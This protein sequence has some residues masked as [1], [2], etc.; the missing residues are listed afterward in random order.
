[1][2]LA[3]KKIE[4]SHSGENMAAIIHKVARTYGFRDKLGY[5]VMD[6]A[7]N[8]DTMMKVI[9]KNLYDVDGVYYDPVEH[10]L[11]CIG[12]IINLFVQAFLFGD[13]PD[14]DD[15]V[16]TAGPT[17]AELQAYRKFEPLGKLHNVI[18]Y[19]MHSTQRIQRFKA[20]SKGVMPVRD[21]KIRWNTWFMVLERALDKIKDA[22]QSF[23]F[24]EKELANDVL[25]ASDWETLLN[26][27]NFLQPFYEATK[28]C[29]GRKA[30][31]NRV[32]PVL[33]FLLEK[34]E[35]G[36]AQYADDEYMKLSIDSGWLKLQEYW[37]RTDRAPV[38][39][40]AMVLDPTEKWAYFERRWKPEW[41]TEA[42]LTMQRLWHSY[43]SMTVAPIR[44]AALEE[45]HA[46]TEFM[47]WMEDDDDL[48][49]LDELK[50]YVNEP[51]I[52]RKSND[53]IIDVIT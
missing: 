23:I 41:V 33:D 43:S 8:N 40:A 53:H 7:S 37:N 10:R 19:I 21:H 27:R 20:L 14:I 18:I 52:Q 38:Y 4:G 31:I 47:A 46:T 11:R 9:S 2:L 25:T 17:D 34:Y 39:I 15:E 36:G 28:F 48:V 42:K 29:E 22:L 6:N 24:N 49:P 1:M 16:T 35:E 12:H 5:F 26:I 3:L 30:T 45:T 50:Q 51:R 32:L 13:H 44:L